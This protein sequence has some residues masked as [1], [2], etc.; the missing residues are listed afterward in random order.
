VVAPAVALCAL[1]VAIGVV[2][3]PLPIEL[4]WA[5]TYALLVA[6]PGWLLVRLAL[7]P[8]LGA[9]RTERALLALGAGYVLAMLTG[10]AAILPFRTVAGWQIG[11]LA[12][13]LVAGLAL[14]LA[15]RSRAAP[16]ASPERGPAG[17]SSLGHAARTRG[18]A[19]SD[20]SR[21]ARPGPRW[22]RAT[23]RM[24]PASWNF[25]LLLVLVVA[26]VPRLY[27]LGWSEFQGDEAR[28]LLR[29]MAALQGI[30]DAL[31]AHRKVPGEIVLT[32]AFYGQLGAMTELVGR[33][34]FALAGVAGVLAFHVLARELV[35]ARAG[36]VAALLIAVNGYFV[37]FG[38]ILQY[39]S[40]AFFLGT[41]GLLCCHRFAR[42]ERPFAGLALLGSMCLFGAVLVALGAIFFIP[43]ALVLLLPALRRI[44][45]LPACVFAAALWPLAPGVVAAALVF[46]PAGG[47]EGGGV[48]SYLG[49]RLGGSRPYWNL[50]SLLRSANHYLSTPYLALTVAG[51]VVMLAGSTRRLLGSV[52]AAGALLRVGAALGIAA[53][54]WTRPL[55]AGA[56]FGFVLA[57]A[58][59]VSPRVGLGVR[60]ALAWA[61]GPLFVH[62]FLVRFSGTHWREAWPGLVLLT[63]VAIVALMRTRPAAIVVGGLLA[64]FLAAS[65]HYSWVTLVQRQPEYQMVL[66]AG[67]HPLD[68]VAGDG[69][70][71]GGVFGAS[72]RHGW[73]AAGMLVET[74]E[75]PAS[76]ATNE[77]PA[78]AAWYVRR[79]QGCPEPPLL[80][81]RVPRAPQDRNLAGPVPLPAGY[82]PRGEVNVDGYSGI[83]ILA[84]PATSPMG[85]VPLADLARRFDHEDY[86]SPW[87]PVG[88]LY[89]PDL[90][91]A[92]SRAACS[93]PQPA[94]SAGR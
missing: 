28:I 41:L 67:R 66:P 33:L 16:V 7:P 22:R 20:S 5:G 44:R 42:A 92:A 62:L 64:L 74:G 77:S 89:R 81:F 75:L 31:A 85:A 3:A 40:I 12:A 57:C 54:S 65:A 37:A 76:Y 25:P 56:L 86:T 78:I 23:I 48:W 63:A 18:S 71:I 19:E 69:R 8:E 2:C 45:T 83:T 13:A 35:G 84:A 91:A 70:G 27:D 93:A 61:A 72:H 1:F 94:A 73:K 14:E 50:D 15:R 30:P 68:L 39:D 59:A 4:R 52:G 51:G 10:L 46:W 43:P 87:R 17:P 82:E 38:R 80:V 53:L 29:A 11:A 36:L 60:V 58:L 6:L 90:G 34:P 47:G 88:A 32:L 79:P 26:A 55:A 9:G 49:P 21:L 24:L